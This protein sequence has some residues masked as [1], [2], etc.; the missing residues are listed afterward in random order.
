M[1]KAT[2]K[3][4]AISQRYDKVAGREEWRDALDTKWTELLEQIGFL[5]IVLPSHLTDVSG[6]LA[7]IGIDGLIL[8]GGN[9]IGSAPFRDAIE[10]EALL[11]ADRHDLPVLGVC[12][13]MQFLFHVSGGLLRDCSGHVAT[14]HILNG[15]WAREHNFDEVNSY[16]NQAILRVDCPNTFE[17]LATTEDNIVEAFRH[18]EK[19]W[20]GIMW[21]PERENPFKASDLALIKAHFQNENFQDKDLKSNG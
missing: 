21:H 3:L 10:K 4:I 14:I 11:Y 5:P 7:E 18:K 9:D 13:G 19:R 6:F 17:V 1:T 15:Q 20:L 2:K 12:R 16:H 8:S